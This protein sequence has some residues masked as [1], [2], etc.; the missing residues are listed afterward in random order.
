MLLVNKT[1][2][3]IVTGNALGFLT[4]SGN[5]IP[6][7]V[8]LSDFCRMFK[9]KSITTIKVYIIY[10]VLLFNELHKV[11]KRN[12][13]FEILATIWYNIIFWTQNRM[14][15]KLCRIMGRELRFDCNCT[16][17]PSKEKVVQF[18]QSWAMNSDREQ[19]F[20]RNFTSGWKR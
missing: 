7:S 20:M 12:S 18:R 11:I 17:L 8:D 3:L 13:L 16:T 9:V 1:V 2:M 14:N 10:D 4:G 5:A 19:V 15:C 6:F